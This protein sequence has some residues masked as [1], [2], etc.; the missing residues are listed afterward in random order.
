MSPACTLSMHRTYLYVQ[1][2]LCMLLLRT[3]CGPVDLIT[4]D[5]QQPPVMRRCPTKTSPADASWCDDKAKQRAEMNDRVRAM[6]AKGAKPADVARQ[7]FANLKDQGEKPEWLPKLPKRDLGPMLAKAADSVEAVPDSGESAKQ[8]RLR[9]LKT[10]DIPQTPEETPTEKKKK[11]EKIETGN[12]DDAGQPKKKSRVDNADKTEDQTSKKKRTE[13]EVHEGERSKKAKT[14]LNTTDNAQANLHQPD[15]KAKKADGTKESKQPPKECSPDQ[16]KTK[17]TAL[18]AQQAKPAAK[19]KTLASYREAKKQKEAKEQEAEKEDQ[20]GDANAEEEADAEEDEDAEEEADAEEEEDAEEN[21]EE[22]NDEAEEEAEEAEVEEAEEE[23]AEEEEE[24]EDPPDVRRHLK[25][26]SLG[27]VE[28]AKA[29][30]QLTLPEMETVRFYDPWDGKV[31]PIV[32]KVW[33]KRKMLQLKLMDC[34]AV[35]F[36]KWLPEAN[37]KKKAEQGGGLHFSGVYVKLFLVWPIRLQNQAIR[38]I[39]NHSLCA[40]AALEEV[41]AY[42]NLC[43]QS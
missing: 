11:C 13:V 18:A 19:A 8:R 12:A 37:K 1:L 39:S 15:N 41:S 6:V 42:L 17:E 36:C 27:Q 33:P 24:Q 28:P 23:E 10:S 14:D 38:H 22:E 40:I 2:N 35:T 34:P 7:L 16:T 32:L 31:K 43:F 25:A 26:T 9:H 4:P 5:K 30:K 21:E 29:W 20:E 3:S